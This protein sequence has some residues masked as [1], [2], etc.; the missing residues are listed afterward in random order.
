MKGKLSIDI[1]KQA[2]LN[3]VEGYQFYKLYAEK[4]NNEDV[5]RTFMTIADEELTHI[6]F[7]R[8][9]TEN[10]PEENLELATIEAPA[11]GI[12]K[13]TSLTPDEL[14]LAV[15]AFSIAMKMEEESQLF[16]DEAAK[17]TDR[18]DERALLIMLRDWEIHHRDSFK[19]QYD[20]LREEWWADNSYAPF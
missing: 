15:S 5:A 12:F 13:F 1:I 19:K 16:Y 20:L 6:E 17:M 10:T 4:V 18:E 7:L 9:L 3:E 8:K 2:I 14:S 11:P